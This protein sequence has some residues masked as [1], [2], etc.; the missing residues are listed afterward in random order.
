MKEIKIKDLKAGEFFKRKPDAKGV[1]VR[2]DYDRSSKSF[3]AHDFDDICREIFIK[4]DKT[5]FVGF[6]F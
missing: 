1:F 3:S 4:A 5:V 6:T 2:G